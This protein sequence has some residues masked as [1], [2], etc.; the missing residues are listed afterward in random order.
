MAILCQFYVNMPLRNLYFL[1]WV[2]ALPTPFFTMFEK[3]SGLVNGYIPNAQLSQLELVNFLCFINFV[4]LA[5]CY[6]RGS[7]TTQ[8]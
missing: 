4:I 3:T 5:P 1:T 2:L 8:C 6:R 7:W